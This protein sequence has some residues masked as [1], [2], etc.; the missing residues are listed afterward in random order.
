[1]A[2]RKFS[3][4]PHH[5]TV[6]QNRISRYLGELF[7]LKKGLSHFVVRGNEVL[8]IATNV[9]ILSLYYCT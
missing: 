8:D 1:M 5:Y 3:I 9:A 2:F 4:L 6:S 7:A